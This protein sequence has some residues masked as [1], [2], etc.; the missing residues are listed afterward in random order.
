MS[1]WSSAGAGTPESWQVA[2]VCNAVLGAAYLAILVSI[3]VPLA[4]SRQ[5]RSNP[6]ATA[7]AAVFLT[8]AVHHGAQSVQLLLPSLGLADAQGL[9]LRTAWGWPLAAWDVLAA[10][11]GVCYWSIRGSHSTWTQGA[12]LFVDLRAREQQALE[13]NDTVLQGLVVARMALDLEQPAK[14]DEALTASIGA[15]RAIITDLLGHQAHALDLLRS[16]PAAVV[17]RLPQPA[18]LTARVGLERNPR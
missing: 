16:G 9:A 10:L 17:A 4:R 8:C 11:V 3:L 6:L 15:A 12:Q 14:A 1:I 5:L 18:S 13:L 2:L 7:T